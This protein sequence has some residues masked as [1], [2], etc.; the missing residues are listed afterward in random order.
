MIFRPRNT[1]VVLFGFLLIL[2]VG[3]K[4]IN[5]FCDYFPTVIVNTN[6]FSFKEN[7]QLLVG[8]KI[9]QEFKSKYN[10]L[11]TISIKFDTDYKINKDTLRFSIKE[12]NSDNWYY[13]NEYSVEE[14]QNN[15]YY[16]FGFPEIEGSKNK[17]YQIEI[18]SLK[19]T[20]GESV[21]VVA[22]GSYL[23]SRHSFPKKYLLQN[24]NRIPKFL[25]NKIKSFFENIGFK[26]YFRILIISLILWLFLTNKNIKKLSNYIRSEKFKSH[27]SIF[28]LLIIYNI[29]TL[30]F[31]KQTLFSDEA[32]NLIG[33]KMV[34]KGFLIYKDFYS[35]HTPLMYYICGVIS[36]L[37]VNSIV[38]YRISF[39]FL[40]S[41]IWIFIY[42]RYG[43]H[44]G[45]LTMALYPFIYIFILGYTPLGNTILSEQIQSTSLVILLLELLLYEKNK[46]FKY[47]NYLTIAFSIFFSIGTAMVSV[48]PVFIFFVGVFVLQISLILKNKKDLFNYLKSYLFL[49]IFTLVPFLIMIGI[50]YKQ[51]VLS[52]AYYQIFTF[53]TEVYSKYNGGYGSGLLSTLEMPIYKYPSFII[54]VINELFIVNFITNAQLL[55]GIVSVFIFAWNLIRDNKKILGIFSFL[56]VIM[57]GTRSY[58]DFHSIPYFAV[59][60]IIFSMV[61]YN[62][63]Y[64]PYKK[65]KVYKNIPLVLAISSIVILSTSFFSNYHIFGTK[66]FFRDIQ[67]N[68]LQLNILKLTNKNDKIFVN[69]LDGY[70]YLVTNRLPVSKVWSFVPWFADIYQNEVIN[71]LHFNRTK[72]IIYTPELDIWGYK[73][74]NFEA[75]LQKYIENNYTKLHKNDP[76]CIEWIRNDYLNEARKK[77]GI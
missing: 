66:Y 43:K 53:N 40:M 9:E 34:S 55:I 31:A 50:Y 5:D 30:T 24:K 71:D 46:L 12:V 28:G 17:K 58:Q 56:F 33:G 64:L 63:V 44:F 18:I 65:F 70:T 26:N 72:I 10:N 29:L 41:L 76:G 37:G 19:G 3:L 39:F 7:K 51:G 75:E 11:G 57:C 74:K 48:F 8:E 69:T 42:I 35:Q 45:K 68:P 13:T 25:F 1:I 52:N 49:M 54:K 67:L 6:Q 62:F 27:A 21:S 15:K 38:Y 47:D 23:L 61:V 2:I 36:W 59:T 22:K 14:F 60:A 16:S 77:L 73:A 20:K 32:D 4:K